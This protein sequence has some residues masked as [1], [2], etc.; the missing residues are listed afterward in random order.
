MTSDHIVVAVGIVRNKLNQILLSQRRNDVLFPD[1]WEFP[2]GKL[3]SGETEFAALK[4][5]LKE[6]LAITVTDA[7]K[8]IATRHKYPDFDVELK[9]FEVISY[10]GQ[11]QSQEGQ[12]L[13]WQ[14]T[15]N[16]CGDNI[17]PSDL[18]I[19]KALNLPDKYMI[20]PSGKS[21]QELISLIQY[22]NAT[23]NVKMVQYRDKLPSQE[24]KAHAQ[25]LITLAHKLDIKL[26]LNSSIE[27]A[28]ALKA[29][30][31]HL[32]SAHLM[33]QKPCAQPENLLI[34]V[35]CHNA[36]E[37]LQAENINSDFAVLSP[38]MP[39]NTHPKNPGIGWDKFAKLVNGTNIPTYAL[40]GMK[41]ADINYAK[42]LG[43]QGISGISEFM[44][45]KSCRIPK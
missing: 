21:L 28:L 13:K 33:A 8:L 17:L 20:T 39:S 11:P 14:Q 32:N 12:N 38:V 19:I 1:Y 15:K 30:G 24:Y 22:A 3:I 43:G 16:L 31:V 37:L 41:I 5:E 4:R 34:G 42:N 27:L 26:L 44:R 45:I 9:V 2:G 35:S 23:H 7:R 29:H 36:Q 6:E 40:G 25:K 18:P 10:E